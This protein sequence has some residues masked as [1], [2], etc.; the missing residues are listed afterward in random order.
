MPFGIVCDID[1][2]LVKERCV[3][4]GAEEA[5]CSLIDARS[6]KFAAPILF[7]TNGGNCTPSQRAESLSLLLPSVPDITADRVMVAHSPLEGKKEL[8]D[9]RLL[10]VATHAE[11]AHAVA[12]EYGWTSYSVATDLCDDHPYLFP[13]RKHSFT[14]DQLTIPLH[15]Q[16]PF[17]SVIIISTPLDWAEM[18][19]LIVDVLLPIKGKQCTTLYAANPDLV[20]S[21]EYCVPRLTTGAFISCLRTLYQEFTGIPL[22]FEYVGKPLSITYEYAQRRMKEICPNVERFYAIGDNPLSDIQGANASGDGWQSILVLSGVYSGPD[23]H[24]TH[25]AHH[26]CATITEALQ[27]IRSREA[28]LDRTH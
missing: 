28:S 4:E 19:Q 2:V 9:Q 11:V 1:G 21:N 8:R 22:R 14:P 16:E 23:N 13:Y 18:L 26:V 15:E 5:L 17:Q 7:V 12:K 27:Y 25:P 3:I 20:Y 10:L 6:Q 24:P